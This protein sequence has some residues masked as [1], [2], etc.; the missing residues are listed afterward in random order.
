VK[1]HHTAI[2]TIDVDESLRFWRDGLG[3]EPLMDLTFEG[4]W[5][6]LFDAP[7]DT[8]RSVFLG[9]PAARSTGI[10]ELVDFGPLPSARPA[11]GPAVGFF[12]VSVYTD[13]DRTLAVLADLGL[14]GPPR[15]ITV[16]GVDMA[17]VHDPN[18]V[19][20]ELVGLPG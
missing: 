7:T 4:G 1:V 11:A 19:L 9:D 13:V 18:G 3:F 16:S 8:L 14:G 10:I 5:R 6:A 20:V 12:L 2:C 15:R 17:V